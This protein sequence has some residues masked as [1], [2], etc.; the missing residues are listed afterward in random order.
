MAE[1]LGVVCPRRGHTT[2]PISDCCNSSEVPKKPLHYPDQRI[3]KRFE[4][5]VGA[6]KLT[7][8][9]T[10]VEIVLESGSDQGWERGSMV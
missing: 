7:L 9:L 10:A 5:M 8:S 2:R 6:V 1:T 4:A 3:E